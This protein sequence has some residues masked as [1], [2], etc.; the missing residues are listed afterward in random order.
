MRDKKKRMSYR[1]VIVHNALAASPLLTVF[2]Y[3][4]ASDTWISDSGAKLTLKR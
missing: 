2:E 4:P 1:V 3:A